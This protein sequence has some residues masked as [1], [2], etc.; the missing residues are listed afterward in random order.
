MSAYLPS[1]RRRVRLLLASIVVL[2]ALLAASAT[3]GVAAAH[4]D[5][6][7]VGTTAQDWPVGGRTGVLVFSP[8]SAYSPPNNTYNDFAA[9]LGQ[10]ATAVTALPDA[11]TLAGY[12]AVIV[13]PQT[14]SI[15]AADKAALDT[16]ATG[17]GLLIA[18]SDYLMG[19]APFNDLLSTL[20]VGVTDSGGGL[21]AE[22]GDSPRILADPL[23]VGV[24]S[25]AYGYHGNLSV[26]GSARAL[27]RTWNNQLVV[28]AQ[29]HGFGLVTAFAE[30]NGVNDWKNWGWG[31]SDNDVLF[32]NM[33]HRNDAPCPGADL[34][35]AGSITASSVHAGLSDSFD[36]TLTNRGTCTVYDARVR[37][38]WN[39]AGPYFA[40]GTAT[41][42]NGHADTDYPVTWR[43]PRLAV[44]EVATFHLPFTTADT[45]PPAGY[46]IDTLI[47]AKGVPRDRTPTEHAVTLPFTVLDALPSRITGTI[48][49]GGVPVSGLLVVLYD[50]SLGPWSTASW[51]ITGAA[52]RYQFDNLPKH[53][54]RIRVID[55]TATYHSG[56]LSS[57]PFK[58]NQ[59]DALTQ[60]SATAFTVPG[61]GTL[62][63]N[64]YLV[65]AATGSISGTITDG[66]GAPLANAWVQIQ[67]PYRQ[68]WCSCATDG[69]RGFVAGAVTDASGHF[70]IGDL[71]PGRYF[72]RTVDQSTVHA[73]QWYSNSALTS[74]A[75]GIDVTTV[76]VPIT[77][78][79]P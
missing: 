27:V 13:P 56:W 25:Y 32:T 70:H 14:A 18:L 63:R 65:A 15:G 16:Y 58:L 61:G 79:L 36:L 9:T 43:L 37:A 72:V 40:R 46:Q 69:T 44:G 76:D 6:V 75:T 73:P 55:P 38:T 67:L 11:A 57:G 68:P 50:V 48:K 29:G 77:Q 41:V 8:A 78:A 49:A 74:V 21:N 7:P 45:T 64:I 30:I 1:W 23:T 54:Y 31:D 53:V 28:A 2:V 42:S 20:G 47:S 35:L 5:V 34:A 26:T 17:G 24:T 51:R 52:G 3:Q 22:S 60:P 4:G 62:T 10:T 33:A 39:V 71:R 59:L 12:L 19:T 66:G